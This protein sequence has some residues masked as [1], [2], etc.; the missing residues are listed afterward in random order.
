MLPVEPTRSHRKGEEFF[1]G[2]R[3]GNL[4]GRTGI[5][6]LAT[7]KLIPSD[8]LPDHLA[9]LQKLLYP[10]PDDNSRT[11]KLRAIL[12]RTHSCAHTTCFC[13]GEPGE[14]SPRIPESFKSAVAPLVAE[15]ETD[16]SSR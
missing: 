16:Y 6:F 8:D 1:A 14:P 15:I 3:A 2:P 9:F 12:E 11:V 4:R 13:R 10:A 7:D 5:W